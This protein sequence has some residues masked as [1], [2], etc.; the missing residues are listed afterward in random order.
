MKYNVFIRNQCCSCVDVIQYFNN[1]NLPVRIVNLDEE[2]I[3]L[4]FKIQIV[5]ALVQDERL[6]AY[7]SDIIHYFEKRNES[8]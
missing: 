3:D 4:P 2:S 7:G 5:P 8:H 1:S 6:L